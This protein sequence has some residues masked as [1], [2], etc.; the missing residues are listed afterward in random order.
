MATKKPE[1]QI[2]GATALTVLKDEVVIQVIAMDM[3][4]EG[5]LE[6]YEGLLRAKRA[7]SDFQNSIP[8]DI[9][10]LRVIVLDHIV[11]PTAPQ[12]KAR[13]VKRLGMADFG[14]VFDVIV[15][16]ESVTPTNGEA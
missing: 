5:F 11:D 15:G 10:A 6:K 2:D 8:E 7:L 13:L 3:E 4:G 12:E 9:Q 16:R 1:K 14:R